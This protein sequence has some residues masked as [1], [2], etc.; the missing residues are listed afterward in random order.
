MSQGLKR[1]FHPVFAGVS[2]EVS[3]GD[4]QSWKDMGWR[5]TDP[6]IEVSEPVAVEA[7]TAPVK[8]SRS[9]T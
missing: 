1:V 3:E 2:F 9:R 7:E 4:A 5:F 8:E 6:G